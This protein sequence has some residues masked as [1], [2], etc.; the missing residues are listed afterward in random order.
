MKKQLLLSGLLMST[1]VLAQPTGKTGNLGQIELSVTEQ[2][3]AQVAEATKLSDW[4]AYQD[5]TV[6]K[7]PT[8]YQ[9]RS[10]AIAPSFSPEP[11]NPARIAKVEVPDYHRGLV[12]AGYGLYNT[13]FANVYYN[14]KRASSHSYG[15]YADHFST[16]GG[17]KDLLY[18]DNGLSRNRLGGHYNHFY[19]KYTL[20]TAVQGQ[21]D[22]YS[23][24]GQT[25]LPALDRDSSLG[26]APY[27]WYRNLEA[28]ITLVEAQPSSIGWAKELGLRYGLLNN[29][30]GALE[31]DLS[32]RSA[33]VLPADSNQLRVDFNAS[34]FENRFDSLYAGAD[35]SDLFEQQNFQVQA[36]PHMEVYIKNLRFDFGLNLVYW[37][38][39]EGSA[40][41]SNQNFYFFPEVHFNYSIVPEVLSVYA[42]VRGDLKR[43][44]YRQLIADNPY[45]NPALRSRPTAV[46][47]LYFG[48]KG[49]LSS[50]TSFSVQG[51]YKDFDDAVLY[52]RNP[53]F[54][55]D[56]LRPGLAIRYA[57]FNS[58]YVQAE[59]SS[60]VNER[61]RLN[62]RALLRSFDRAS[63][64]RIWHLPWFE[65]SLA[66]HYNLGDKLI[67]GADLQLVGPRQAF[68]QLLR[69]ELESMLAGY[70]DLD[71]QVEYR[72][73][74]RISAYLRG[75]N[76]LNQRYQLFLGYP[77]Q[78]INVLLGFGYRF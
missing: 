26:M 49:K 10:Q 36:R 41:S 73:N 34:Y 61:F 52:Y 40:D 53:D 29:N 60:N 7:L 54:F 48:L 55:T 71:L 11:L 68:D 30:F 46:L 45:L 22:K 24:Y 8:T 13:A 57:D 70:A 15:L 66:A 38:R 77:T 6:E 63:A 37:N 32:F 72:Y 1:L 20:Q 43:N 44:T 3:R 50:S 78:G 74:S 5:S 76:L 56:T 67:L 62:G 16:V 39:R 33:W 58:Y 59:L 31:N 2:Y 25:A 47:D 17:V 64:D 4:P 69:P 21:L 23:Y 75:A 27:N 12:R 35:S 19:R 51:G 9:I 42:G 14:S 65:A 18:E 28:D